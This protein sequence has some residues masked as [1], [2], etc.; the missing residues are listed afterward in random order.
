M[1]FKISGIFYPQEKSKNFLFN[2]KFIKTKKY[3]FVA[4][5]DIIS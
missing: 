2:N 5:N 1:E 4:I 3:K